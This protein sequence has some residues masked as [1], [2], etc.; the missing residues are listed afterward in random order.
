MSVKLFQVR[1][2]HCGTQCHPSATLTSTVEVGFR[3]GNP[4]HSAAESTRFWFEDKGTKH[5][6][7]R[8]GSVL[9]TRREAQRP[10]LSF[11]NSTACSPRASGEET[12]AN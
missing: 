2:G 8:E 10:C 3:P 11:Q 9:L 7:K 12:L 6:S 1:F 5:L 4:V